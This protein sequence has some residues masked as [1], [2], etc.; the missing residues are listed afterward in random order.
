MYKDERFAVI[1]P[2]RNRPETVRTLLR[3]IACQSMLPGRIIIVAS[4]DDIGAVV[5]EFSDSLPVE[6]V[7]TEAGGQIHQRNTGIAMLD[8]RTEDRKSVV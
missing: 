2:T 4:G 8:D 7:F 6:Y 5:A 3:T 1:V